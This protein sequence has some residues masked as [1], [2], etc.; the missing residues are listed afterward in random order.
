MACYLNVFRGRRENQMEQPRPAIE[1]DAEQRRAVR[2]TTVERRL[3]YIDARRAANR[4]RDSERIKLAERFATGPGPRILQ[5]DGYLVLPAGTLAELVEPVVAEGNAVIERIGHHGLVE[6]G[7]KSDFIARG[8][9]PES[10]FAIDSPYFRLALDERIVGPISAYLGVVPVLTEVDVWYS[11]HQPNAP[12]RSQ[13]WHMD[14]DDTTLIKLWVHLSDVDGSSG[15]L[16]AFSANDSAR[17]AQAVGYDYGDGYRVADERVNEVIGS[18]RQVSFVGPRGTLD[19][20][21]T[22]RCFHFGSRVRP[23]GVPR[24][25]LM[26]EYQTPY[27]FEFANYRKEARYRK[28]VSETSANLERLLLGAD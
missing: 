11:V 3:A 15:P 6:H 19:F 9:L 24:R 18:E 12:K 17:L 16:T 1:Q 13:L 26:V 23:D 4:E 2:R 25:L 7:G 28:L 22:C 27:A 20:I 21:D 14:S 5:E 8:F 10:A